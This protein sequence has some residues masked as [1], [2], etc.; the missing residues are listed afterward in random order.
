MDKE[1]WKYDQ[2]WRKDE[3][4]VCH[5]QLELSPIGKP[6]GTEEQVSESSHIKARKPGI[7]PLAS[8]CC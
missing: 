1:V 7:R 2:E 8:I 4:R 6:R 3:K 5:V